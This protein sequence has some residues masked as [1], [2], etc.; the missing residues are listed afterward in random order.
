[1]NKLEEILGITLIPGTIISNATNSTKKVKKNSIFF[2][3]QG[4]NV[5]GS[6]YI[7]EAIDLGASVAV[8]NDVNY[9]YSSDNVFYIDDLEEINEYLL[10]DKIYYFLEELY[11][12]YDLKDN[13]NFYAFTGT[14]G[15]TSSAYLC[16]QILTNQG[17]NSLYIG[18][19]GT[20]YKN[21][22]T[23]RSIFKKTTPDIF[24]LFEIF[25][26]YNFQDSISICLEV[27]S[28]ALD[29]KR[30]K[31]LN[32]FNS[33][34]ILNIKKDHLDYHKDI[35]AYTNSKFEIFKIFSP[36]NLI[37]DELKSIISDYPFLDDS[38]LSL[39]TISKVNRLADIH[40]T[41]S[42]TS[43]QKSDF[44]ITINNPPVGYHPSEKKT[45]KFRCS[46]IPNFNISNLVFAIC[47][48]G[49]SSFSDT[50]TN[51][52]SYLKL[53]KGR[54]D[55]IQDI[56][57]NVMIDY[58]HN[59]DGFR[60]FLSGIKDYYDSL[61]IVFGCGGDRDKLKRPE[62]LQVA[63]EYGREIIFT[64]DNSRSEDFNDILSDAIRGN[65]SNK[66][67]AI[68][69]RKIAIMK[70]A[71]LIKD[72]DCLVILGKGHEETQETKNS[73]I[74]FSDHEVVNEIYK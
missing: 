55:N 72:N 45:Y 5:H 35:K 67:T 19:I 49:F 50:N 7:K 44:D 29:Q 60:I 58:A 27:S 61:V 43:L 18:T 51:D 39:K 31:N 68:E 73:I 36:I 56:P 69:D 3:L 20:Q 8:H 54:A 42:K 11:K 1:M 53:P 16:H 52:L 47:S 28:H 64:S 9:K 41:I 34:S 74:H 57:I 46:L 37:N 13:N 26:F 48:L 24:E 25:N 15:K 10:K 65:D 40:Y 2:G 33:A 63:L 62:M 4:T 30:L 14:N 6:K 66:V 17:F 71:E 21:Q 70:G 12:V 38:K 23:N 59:P 22:E 32:H